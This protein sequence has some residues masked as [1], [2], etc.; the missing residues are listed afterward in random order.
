MSQPLVNKSVL[1]FNKIKGNP[2]S[3]T[4]YTGASKGIDWGSAQAVG[5]APAPT[6][7]LFKAPTG[8][9]SPLKQIGMNPGYMMSLP[10]REVNELA[11]KRIH[12][13]KGRSFNHQLLK[14]KPIT[15]LDTIAF[16]PEMR[17]GNIGAN[18]TQKPFAF[19]SFSV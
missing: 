4:S 6:S 7:K 18:L 11:N 19:S 3:S 8:I 9:T 14:A 1:P 17:I 5:S 12:Q 15:G 16:S 13:G 10:C 2:S